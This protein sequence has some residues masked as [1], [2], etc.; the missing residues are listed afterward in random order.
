MTDC[1]LAEMCSGQSHNAALFC[2]EVLLAVHSSAYSS[3]LDPI[4]PSLLIGLHVHTSNVSIALGN[5]SSSTAWKMISVHEQH[6]PLHCSSDGLTD[7]V[8]ASPDKACSRAHQMSQ[9]YALPY[10]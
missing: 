1:F 5:C 4:E 7:S 6:V 2:S 10:T 8:P 3:F 9:G